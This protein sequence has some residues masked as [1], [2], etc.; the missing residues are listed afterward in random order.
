MVLLTFNLF[1]YCY[2]KVLYKY[3]KKRLKITNGL[4]EAVNRRTDN[5]VTK[6]KEKDIRTNNEI[7]NTAQKTKE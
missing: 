3:I 6:R 2:H 4:S 7:Q 5:T 1:N